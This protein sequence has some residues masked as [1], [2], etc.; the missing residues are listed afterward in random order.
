MSLCCS[1]SSSLQEDWLHFQ[2]T[3][4][5]AASFWPLNRLIHSKARCGDWFFPLLTLLEALSKSLLSHH[6]PGQFL[7]CFQIYYGQGT[8]DGLCGY[9]PAYVDT[10]PGGDFGNL[11]FCRQR[12]RE[13]NW[14]SNTM[15]W[16]M[17]SQESRPTREAKLGSWGQGCT[18]VE[19]AQI[20]KGWREGSG[21]PRGQDDAALCFSCCDPIGSSFQ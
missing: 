19:A 6:Y 10:L 21:L 18:S 11:G 9:T 15:T 7:F 20:C 3:A 5:I 2:P 17:Q 8:W 14:M 13:W 4:S 12:Q 1:S 16:G